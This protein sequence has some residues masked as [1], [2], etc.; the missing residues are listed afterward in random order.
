MLSASSILKTVVLR[1]Q[2]PKAPF[3]VVFYAL[4]SESHFNTTQESFIPFLL[5]IASLYVFI[6]P[7]QLLC[8]DCRSNSQLSEF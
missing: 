5:I 1:I 7:H 8:S 3:Y 4:E 2:K 6:G